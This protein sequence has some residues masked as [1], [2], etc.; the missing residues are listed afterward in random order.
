MLN[1]IDEMEI[2]S[3]MHMYTHVNQ[4]VICALHVLYDSPYTHITIAHACHQLALFTNPQVFG[5]VS[6][7]VDPL[8]Q[9]PLDKL[10]V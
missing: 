9:I 7:S 4:T 8:L 6:R 10:R 3:L 1:G 5:E 2:C